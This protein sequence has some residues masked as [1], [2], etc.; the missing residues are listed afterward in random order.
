[1]TYTSTGRGWGDLLSFTRLQF[2]GQ[3]TRAVKTYSRVK[4][5]LYKNTLLQT[6]CESFVL[7]W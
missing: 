2:F 6:E 5:I 3:A 4:L 7:Q 1:M